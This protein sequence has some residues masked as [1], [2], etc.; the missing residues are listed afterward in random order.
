MIRHVTPPPAV[1]PW[2]AL[3]APAAALLA[4]ACTAPTPI[5]ANVEIATARGVV[6]AVHTEDG[7]V[8]LKELVPPDGTTITFR[9]RHDAGIFDDEALLLRATDEVALLAPISS[10]PN[11]ARFGRYPAAAGER[12]FVEVRTGDHPDLLEC[13]LLDDGARGD[14]IALVEGEMLDVA[15]RYCGAGV[16]AWR[17]GTLEL[18]GMLNGVVTLE[19]A[20]LAFIGLDEMTVLLPGT[21]NYF[22]RRALPRR[23]DF[24]FGI[25]RDFAGE[26]P[27]AAD[28]MPAVDPA[29]V[30]DPADD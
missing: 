6:R 23:A 9:G 5:E 27:A 28:A 19:P 22:Q 4:V 10:R 8:A 15:T 2:R 11:A 13:R 30:D 21:S 14:L 12:L 17:E 3:A 1:L 29:A 18:V 20:A 26:K 24:E 25:P 7:I 16:F